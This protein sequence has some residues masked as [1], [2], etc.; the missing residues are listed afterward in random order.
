[1]LKFWIKKLKFLLT[2][3]WWREW[4]L[5]REEWRCT[6]KDMLEAEANWEETDRQAVERL[7]K[8]IQELDNEQADDTT[9][10][11]P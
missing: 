10:T 8:A 7:L 4:Q 11:N 9:P 3:I 5:V 2:F 1:M 6:Y